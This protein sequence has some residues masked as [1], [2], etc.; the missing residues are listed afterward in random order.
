V[1]GLATGT[2]AAALVQP[3]AAACNMPQQQQRRV[4]QVKKEEEE[5]EV[6][7]CLQ[8]SLFDGLTRLDSH[9]KNTTENQLIHE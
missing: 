3:F 9:R 5:K 6:K 1:Q 8:Y 7:V 4:W 2:A